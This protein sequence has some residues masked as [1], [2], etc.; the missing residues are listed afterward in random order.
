MAATGLI[1]AKPGRIREANEKF[2]VE[3]RPMDSRQRRNLFIISAVLAGVGLVGFTVVLIGV[4]GGEGLTV[5]DEPI[6]DWLMAGRSKTWTPAM[7][8]LSLVF[9][10]LFFP[11]MTLAITVAW[12]IKA[13][14]LWRPLL[15]AG[16]TLVGIVAVR[17]IAEVVGRARPPVED[18]LTDVDSS[19]SFPSGHVIG[20]AIF[21]LLIAYLVFSRRQARWIATLSFVFAGI[22][23]IA[24]ALSRLYLGYHWATDAIGAIFLALVVL[25]AA[26]AIDTKRTTSAE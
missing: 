5:I 1:G 21:I 11:Y 14:H 23:V 13:R 6:R 9:G 4:L 3:R 17:G 19:E 2:L 16:G 8:V 18:M 24:T 20:A 12:V 26:M 22:A 15:L 10:P 7:L 25:G